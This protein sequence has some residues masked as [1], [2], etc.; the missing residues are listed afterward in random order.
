VL[1]RRAPSPLILSRGAVL[2]YVAVKV[3][4]R[5]TAISASD[6]FILISKEGSDFWFYKL[7]LVAFKR[8]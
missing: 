3:T 6:D 4:A 1:S 5:V 8:G 2:G 7:R